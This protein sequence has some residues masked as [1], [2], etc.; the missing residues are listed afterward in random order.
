MN[1]SIALKTEA[2]ALRGSHDFSGLVFARAISEDVA[3]DAT[4]SIAT[5]FRLKPD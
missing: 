3:E 1:P 5:G 2:L 4:E